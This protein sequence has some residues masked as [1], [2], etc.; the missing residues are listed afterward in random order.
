MMRLDF[1]NKTTDLV[2][3]IR[4]RHD[5]YPTAIAGHRACCKL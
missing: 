4:K 2:E 3:E 5:V 1:C